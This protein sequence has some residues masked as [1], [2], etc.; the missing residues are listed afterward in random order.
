MARNFFPI[1][2]LLQTLEILS[3]VHL[4]MNKHI[5]EL[6]FRRETQTPLFIPSLDCQTLKRPRPGGR[7]ISV[8]K[9][10]TYMWRPH[11]G[12]RGRG[13]PHSILE[14]WGRVNSILMSQTTNLCRRL[15]RVAPHL[16]IVSSF[17]ISLFHRKSSLWWMF[18]LLS[19]N[20][21]R[22]LAKCLICQ[23]Q[24]ETSSE[25]RARERCTNIFHIVTQI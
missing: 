12:G 1:L 2:N 14:V 18:P 4:A 24:L 11:L 15:T 6:D 19:L 16:S 23:L 22:S 17:V 13:S 7:L 25:R 3:C 9:G 8:F 5:S 20:Q 10:H 21:R